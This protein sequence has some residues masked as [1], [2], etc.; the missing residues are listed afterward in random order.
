MGAGAEAGEPPTDQGETVT[1]IGD[2]VAVDRAD[3]GV[4]AQVGE[5]SRRLEVLGVAIGAQP[6][7]AFESGNARGAPRCR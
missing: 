2:R 5:P 7:I 6:L 3:P 4:V 1:L